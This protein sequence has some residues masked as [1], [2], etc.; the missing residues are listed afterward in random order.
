MNLSLFTSSET[1][2]YVQNERAATELPSGTEIRSAKTMSTDTLQITK[3][4][5]PMDPPFDQ[6]EKGNDKRFAFPKSNLQGPTQKLLEPVLASRDPRISNI[7]AYTAG[8]MLKVRREIDRYSEGVKKYD[9]NYVD[10]HDPVDSTGAEKRKCYVPNSLRGALPLHHSQIVENDSRLSEVYAEIKTERERAMIKHEEYKNKMAL[11]AKKIAEFEIKA[12]KVLLK[13]YYGK[14]LLWLAQ[15]LVIIGANKLKVKLSVPKY[16][17]AMA[18]IKYFGTKE[19]QHDETH[20]RDL[21]F[22]GYFGNNQVASRKLSKLNFVTKIIKHKCGI[23]DYDNGIQAK[24][25]DGEKDV[26]AYA[27]K[28]LLELMPQI[29]TSY[30]RSI[31]LP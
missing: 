30:W 24:M 11:H 21:E 5:P 13:D 4:P 25:N 2:R 23:G 17:V 16:H 1:H 28:I 14:S 12:R 26:A 31:T 18:A 8:H 29:T 15:S 22:P 19:G 20:W 7:I 10:N 6:P 3:R 27:G 9:G